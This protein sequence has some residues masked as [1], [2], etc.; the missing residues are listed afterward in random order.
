MTVDGTSYGHFSDY[1]SVYLTTDGSIPVVGHVKDSRTYNGYAEDSITVI[2]YAN[3]RVQQVSVKRCDENGNLS[4]SGTGIKI[5]AT[6]N[7]QPVISNGVQKNFCK[8]QYRYK[9]ESYSYYSDWVTILEATDLSSD[10]V[11]TGALRSG[12]LSADTSYRVEVRVVDDIG[13]TSSSETIVSTAKVYWHRD[14]ARNS[15]GLGKYNERD[16]AL[17]SGWDFYMNEHKITGL[18][19]PVD[20]TDAVTLGYLKEYIKDY[21]ANLPKG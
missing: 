10:T 7:Y 21:I 1:T 4:D 3:P 13:N 12:E 20:N 16:N 2:P 9:V 18:A 8:I 6:R 17:D 19:D 11:T 15:L 5:T 14:G